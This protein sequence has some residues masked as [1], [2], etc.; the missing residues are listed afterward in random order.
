MRKLNETELFKLYLSNSQKAAIDQALNVRLNQNIGVIA[1]ENISTELFSLKAASKNSQLQLLPEILSLYEN[2]GRL[3][4]FNLGSS[5]KT[6]PIP[7]FMP[8]SIGRGRDRAR[9]S[10]APSLLS[11]EV[12]VVFINMFRIG[13]WSADEST[14]NGL[15]ARTD[16]YTCLE[17]GAINYFLSNGKAEKVFSDPKILESLTKIYTSLFSSAV[18]GASGN[19]YGGEDFKTDA[20]RFIIANFFLRYVLKKAPSEGIDSYAYKATKYRTSFKGVK[21]YE[22][23]AFINYESLS[24]F[25]SSFGEVFFNEP[26]S[27]IDFEN[28]WLTNYGE[29]LLF[30]I[31]YVPYLLHFLFA[32]LHHAPLGGVVRLGNRVNELTKEGLVQLYNSVVA[33]V[34]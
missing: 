2:Y 11:G 25:L 15:N 28:K 10:S 12:P 27:L 5:A 20:A 19:N 8:F 16:L 22:E 31:E 30:A 7:L 29:G 23:N 6:S 4:L 13:N 34:K 33:A 26:I 21:D 18:L 3:R 24:G 32:A 14:Y 9:E 17:T 1:P